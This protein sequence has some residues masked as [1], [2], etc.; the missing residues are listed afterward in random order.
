MRAGEAAARVAAGGRLDGAVER[1]QRAACRDG[2][3]QAEEAGPVEPAGAAA[4]GPAD[5]DVPDQDRGQ[6]HGGEGVPVDQAQP[7]DRD[8][9]GVG[10]DDARDEHRQRQCGHRQER[11]AGR[12]LRRRPAQRAADD[13]RLRQQQ[14]DDREPGDGVREEH[15]RPADRRRRAGPSRPVAKATGTS[16]RSAWFVRARTHAARLPRRRH[17]TRRALRAEHARTPRDPSRDPRVS[18]ARLTRTRHGVRPHN[19][20]ISG[21]DP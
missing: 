21:S 13:A 2:A 12:R 16:S 20:A 4:G 3:G 11:A 1:G 15:E 6:Q 18:R 7:R 10:P 8:R 14:R 17:A 9:P 19:C 5:G